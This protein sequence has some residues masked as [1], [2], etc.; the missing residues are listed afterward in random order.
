MLPKSYQLTKEKDF[1][2]V[3]KKGKFHAYQFLMCKILKT[4]LEVSRFGIVVGVKVSKKAT[5][6]NRAKRRLREAIGLK[7]DKIKKGFD[8]VVMVKPEIVDKTYSEIDQ[9]LLRLFK[10]AKLIS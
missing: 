1:D 9:A 5:K 10:K 2:Q 6:R 8:L 4:N 3:Y 7:L